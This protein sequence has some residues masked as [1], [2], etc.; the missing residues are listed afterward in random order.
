MTEE[1]KRLEFGKKL[2]QGIHLARKRMLH[3]K[4]LRG[5]DV[6]IGDGKGGI[7]RIAAKKYITEHAEYQ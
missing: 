7:M 6:I 1:Q 3:E 5:Q 4:A 2:E